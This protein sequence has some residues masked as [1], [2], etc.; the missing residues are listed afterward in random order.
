[1]WLIFSNVRKETA[2]LSFMSTEDKGHSTENKC[3]HFTPWKSKL[4]PVCMHYL[5]NNTGCYP[6]PD[7]YISSFQ[8]A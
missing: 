8:A 1:M 2:V 4:W 6:L 3:K 5:I 7:S